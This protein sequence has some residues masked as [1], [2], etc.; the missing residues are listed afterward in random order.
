MPMHGY[1]ELGISP[2]AYITRWVTEHLF[3]AHYYSV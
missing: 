2:D 3:D 1:A